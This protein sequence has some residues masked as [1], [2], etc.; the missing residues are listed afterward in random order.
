VKPEPTSPPWPWWGPP[1]PKPPWVLAAEEARSS[2]GTDRPAA[3]PTDWSPEYRA[4]A[5]RALSCRLF[6][7]IGAAELFSER[8]EQW[9]TEEEL[10]TKTRLWESDLASQRLIDGVTNAANR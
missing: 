7:N 5:R 10:G 9:L 6:E 1:M 2:V 4:T 8:L 3:H